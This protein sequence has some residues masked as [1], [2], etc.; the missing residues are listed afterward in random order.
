MWRM[1]ASARSMARSSGRS[2]AG[3]EDSPQVQAPVSFLCVK[4]TELPL[5]ASPVQE[6]KIAVQQC[7]ELRIL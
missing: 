5:L 6:W 2:V 1:H 4:P 3:T 7:L